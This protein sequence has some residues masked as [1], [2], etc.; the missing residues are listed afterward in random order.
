MQHLAQYSSNSDISQGI[1]ARGQFDPSDYVRLC[2]RFTLRSGTNVPT[3][4]AFLL[5][6]LGL[7]IL[8]V[9]ATSFAMHFYQGRNR[10]ALQ[11]RVEN[12]E[13]DLESLGI[14][15]LRV[16]QDAIDKLDTI[17]YVP[18]E[19]E[20]DDKGEN[21]DHMSQSPPDPVLPISPAPNQFLWSQPT[22]PIC[23]EDFAAHQT[24]VR[25]L[26]CHHIYHPACIDAFLRDSS[27]LC[28]V[29][30]A[31]ALPANTSYSGEP[32]TN[33]MVRYERRMRR[34]NQTRE[35]RRR[36]R[37]IDDLNARAHGTPA[38]GD[39]RWLWH[40][41]SG[42][43]TRVFSV[44]GA[45]TSSQVEMGTMG[46]PAASNPNA[47]SIQEVRGS[48]VR[49]PP[50]VVNL[51]GERMRRGVSALQTR[52]RTLHDEEMADLARPKCKCLSSIIFLCI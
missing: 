43:R 10:R 8:I 38:Q 31:R 13:V 11:R 16:P 17:I 45:R 21:M 47:T 6:V 48:V 18:T 29:C 27:S 37:E 39:G 23:L 19:E 41:W 25:S 7:V 35:L 32:I 33:A 15:R 2:T 4:W 49:P 51:R 42:R 3:L 28:P 50:T 22:C 26:P 40:L 52:S 12:G 9:A 24:T 30:K 14:K 20:S 44:S 5:I 34:M 1:L 46:T 36:S